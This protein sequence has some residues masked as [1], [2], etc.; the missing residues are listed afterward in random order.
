MY[1]DPGSFAETPQVSEQSMRDFFWLQGTANGKIFQESYL[2]LGHGCVSVG[3]LHLACT[4]SHTIRDC[5]GIGGFLLYQR[6]GSSV[7]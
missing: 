1:G 6:Q 2:T 3:H 4:A 5:T 7:L